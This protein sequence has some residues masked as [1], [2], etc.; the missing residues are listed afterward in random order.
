MEQLRQRVIASY[1]LGPLDQAETEAYILHRLQVAG[2]QG[3][4]SFASDAF[5]AIY[6]YTGGIPRRINI[7]CER[8]MLMGCL[9]QKHAFAA[10]EVAVVTDEMEQELAPTAWPASQER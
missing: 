1:H 3:D 7:L 4:P 5:A 8:L 2:W 9:D 6:Q 10:A